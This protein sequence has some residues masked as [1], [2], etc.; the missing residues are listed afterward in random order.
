MNIINLDQ[1]ISMTSKEIAELTGKR[2]DNVIRDVRKMLDEIYPDGGLLSFEDTY[3]N[4]QNGET[5]S[6]YRLDRKHTFILVA[7][8]SV[9]LRAKCYDH[10]Q[11]LEQK[12]LRLEDQQKRAAVQS[13]NRRGVT[14]GDYCK[15]HGLPAQKLMNILKRE[16]KLFQV[17]PVS[18][19]WSVN[20]KYAEYFR[21]I[22]PTD[23]RFNPSG[24]NIRFNAK[25]LEF[26]GQPEHVLKMR[27]KVIEIH[28]TDAEKQKH[29]QDVAST[30]PQNEGL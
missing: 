30:A 6:M 22:K 7:G 16:R 3:V 21:V 1:L 24:I 17:H 19:E 4:T 13:A 18:G 10:I 20:P 25:G 23:Q 28:G 14:W 27:G 15:T 8:Y 5:Y 26:F 9:Q 11:M 2:H 29:L 12:V